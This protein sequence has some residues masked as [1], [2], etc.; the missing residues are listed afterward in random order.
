MKYLLVVDLLV[1]YFDFDFDFGTNKI[2]IFMMKNL[3][4]FILYNPVNSPFGFV[5]VGYDYDIDWT[6]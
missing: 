3:L 6:N 1:G 5:I 4:V 2:I